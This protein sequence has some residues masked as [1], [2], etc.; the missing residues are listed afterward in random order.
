M[1]GIILKY[2]NMDRCLKSFSKKL[3]IGCD[4]TKPQIPIPTCF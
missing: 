2:A 4:I 3:S 1:V